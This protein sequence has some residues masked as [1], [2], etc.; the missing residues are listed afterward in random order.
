MTRYQWN[1]YD[2]YYIVENID[3]YY[4]METQNTVHWMP[5][6]CNEQYMGWVPH[7]ID[8]L[9]THHSN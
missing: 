6:Q 2:I 5:L 3:I 4:V 9:Y 1:I 8:I 7:W